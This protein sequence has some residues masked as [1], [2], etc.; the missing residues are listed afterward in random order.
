MQTEQAKANALARTFGQSNLQVNWQTATI[1][2]A[3]V[4]GG[5]TYP[6]LF[7]GASDD[8]RYEFQIDA[9]LMGCGFSITWFTAA[10]AEDACC[11]LA[12]F[13]RTKIRVVSSP[14]IIY[15]TCIFTQAATV[16]NQLIQR[17]PGFMFPMPLVRYVKAGTVMQLFGS[18]QTA[19][20]WKNLATLYYV[21]V[22]DYLKLLEQANV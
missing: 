9:V 19:I 10:A 7:P 20:A 2:L 14:N 8:S 1:E 6:F 18:K 21:T 5:A 13:S 22:P 16:P 12:P 4:G 17:N 3:S 11:A 15:Q